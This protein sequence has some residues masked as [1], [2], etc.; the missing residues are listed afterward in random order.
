MADS[1]VVILEKE[2]AKELIAA[3]QRTLIH[4]DDSDFLC[5]DD[6]NVLDELKE[7]LKIKTGESI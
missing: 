2:Y 6:Y 5:T 4:D 7:T 1:V 3:I